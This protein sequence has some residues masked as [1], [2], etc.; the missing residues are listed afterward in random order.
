MLDG[1]LS[2]TRD[3]PIFRPPR[4]TPRTLTRPR[5]DEHSRGVERIAQTLALARHPI[6]DEL[7]PELDAVGYDVYDPEVSRWQ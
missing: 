3:G 6:P 1:P 4:P 5:P 2:G 7:W